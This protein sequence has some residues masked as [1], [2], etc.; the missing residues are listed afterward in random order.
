[1]FIANVDS[2]GYKVY[3]VQVADKK[4]GKATD[5]KVTEHTLENAKYRVVFNKNGDIATIIDKKLKM[6]I[7]SKPI[8]LAAMHDIGMLN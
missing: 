6:Q 3:D 4:Y 2:V 5:L 8:K 1:M 7:L